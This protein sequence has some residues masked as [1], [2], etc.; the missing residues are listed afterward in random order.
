M[1]RLSHSVA[2]DKLRIWVVIWCKPNMGSLG[3]RACPYHIV[4]DTHWELETLPTQNP[5]EI[6]PEV[7]N[8]IYN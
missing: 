1:M 3:C 6:D 5:A 8:S 4:G 2:S 7:E